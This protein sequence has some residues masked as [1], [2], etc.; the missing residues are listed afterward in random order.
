MTG[1]EL[2]RTFTL[3]SAFKEGDLTVGG[4]ADDHLREDARRALLAATVGDI[5]RSPPID[6]GVT[7][8]LDRSRDR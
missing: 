3:A 8:A 1:Q 5:R 2:R 4:T 6:D 7:A